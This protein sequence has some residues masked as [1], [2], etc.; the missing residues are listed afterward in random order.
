[1]DP[2]ASV[3]GGVGGGLKIGLRVE[4]VKHAW[5]MSMLRNERVVSSVILGHC[6]IGF[7]KKYNVC[8]YGFP[9]G[10]E[11]IKVHTKIGGIDDVVEVGCVTEGNPETLVRFGWLIGEWMSISAGE[12]GEVSMWESSTIV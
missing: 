2:S 10:T 8:V 9:K 4:K 3:S 11:C 5:I 1:M 6:R 12:F 7:V